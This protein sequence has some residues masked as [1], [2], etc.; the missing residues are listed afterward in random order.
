VP[1]VNR[2]IG[3]HRIPHHV[4]D[5]RDTPL[6]SA[7]ERGEENINFGKMKEDYFCGTVLNAITILMRL[8][9]FVFWCADFS[10]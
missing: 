8:A 9:K 7:A 10:D 5:D 2:H 4:R 3:V 6:V 1:L